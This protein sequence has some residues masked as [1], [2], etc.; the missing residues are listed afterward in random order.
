MGRDDISNKIREAVT[1]QRTAVKPLVPASWL[2]F[3]SMAAIFAV[4]ATA[5]AALVLRA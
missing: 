2:L 4:A 5:I 3:V 1:D